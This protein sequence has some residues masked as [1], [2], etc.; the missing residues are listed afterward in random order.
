MVTCLKLN[1]AADIKSAISLNGTDKCKN[2]KNL[3]LN[4]KR[5]NCASAKSD[6]SHISISSSSDVGLSQMTLDCSQSISS[7]RASSGSLGERHSNGVG[8][9]LN[10]RKDRGKAN[11]IRGSS[12]WVSIT[13]PNSDGTSR[14]MAKRRRLSDNGN[15]DSST[16]GASDPFAFDDVDQE[17]LNWGLFGS[18]KKSSQGSQAKS[19]NGKLSDDCEI[20]AI[21]TQESCQPEDNHQLGSTSPSNLDDESSLLEECLLASIKVSLCYFCRLTSGSGSCIPLKLLCPFVSL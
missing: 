21:G 11:P 15:S 18:K 3:S 7:N 12:G 9:K 19:A 17:P 1:C 13:G 16:G 4:L 5:Q 6:V 8:L 14:E 10:V 2:S 20:A